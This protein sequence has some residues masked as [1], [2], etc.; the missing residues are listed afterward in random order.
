MASR[1]D[2]TF[3]LDSEGIREVLKS[4][5]VKAMVDEAAAAVAQHIQSEVRA[6]VTVEVRPYTTDREA[7]TVVVPD[8]RAMAWQARDGIVTRAAASIGAEV[9]ERGR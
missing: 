7:A 1:T 6:G 2:V 3:E 9:K 8:I 5:E 4:P